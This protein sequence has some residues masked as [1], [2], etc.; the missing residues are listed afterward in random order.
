[1]PG[2]REYIDSSLQSTTRCAY[3][4]N[5]YVSRVARTPGV[6]CSSRTHRTRRS[7]QSLLMVRRPTSCPTL[8]RIASACF[9]RAY[10]RPASLSRP[11]LPIAHS[12]MQPNTPANA[13]NARRRNRR[14]LRRGGNNNNAAQGTAPA[15]AADGAAAGTHQT[16]G[17]RAGTSTTVSSLLRIPHSPHTKSD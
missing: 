12:V 15:Q 9:R 4:S 3:T 6:G 13:G 7:K 2:Q 16:A 17:Q 14:R 5:G 11:Y 10:L 8:P 1:M